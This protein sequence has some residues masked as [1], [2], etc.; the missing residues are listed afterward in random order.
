MR[1]LVVR[2]EPAASATAARLRALG[3]E[4]VVLP[5]LATEPVAWQP[6]DTLPDAVVLTSA[7]AVR[8]AGTQVADLQQLPALCVGEATAA[9]ARAAGWRGAQPGPGTL[10]ALLDEAI[11]GPHRTLLHLAGEDRT[12]ARVPAGLSIITLVVYRARLLPLP[13]LLP[14]EGILLHSPRT[15]RHLAAEWDRL[16]GRRLDVALFAISEM[17]L[18]AAGIGW[19]ER[20][21][22]PH[23]GEDALLAMLPK[24]L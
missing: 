1:I 13:M 24:A 16:G 11:G 9:A 2:P 3:H 7:A 4:P 8:H 19:R 20:R 6:P 15:A 17:T 21:A 12:E 18:A 14:V 23:P 5:L 22:A 10:Q